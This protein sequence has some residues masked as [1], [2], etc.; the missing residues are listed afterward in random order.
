MFNLS[1]L[2]PLPYLKQSLIVFLMM[3]L[4]VPINYFFYPPQKAE[5]GGLGQI[6]TVVGDRSATGIKTMVES[7]LTTVNTFLTSIGITNLNLKE[8][9]WDGLFN[10]AA[11]VFLRAMVRSIIVWINSGFKGAPLFITDMKSFLLDVADETIGEMI[12]KNED[13]NFLCS[14]FQLDVKIALATTYSQGREGSYQPQCTLS[15]VTD[16]VEGFM[17]GAF[18]QGGWPG[19]LELTISE[20]SN[21]MQAYLGARME[22]YARII[23]AQGEEIAKR[24]V[25]KNMLNI[26][27]CDVAEKQAGTEENCLIGT[28]GSTI[29]EILN[30]ALGAEQEVLIEADEINEVFNALIS[31]IMKQ[32]FTG[33][34]GLL[35]LG[36]NSSYTNY[37]WDGSNGTSSILDAHEQDDI[38]TSIDTT[39]VGAASPIG[40][41]IADTERFIE[42]KYEI[43]G[44]INAAESNYN[45]SKSSLS[46]Q[47][48]NIGF[49]FP[50]SLTMDRQE[51]LNDIAIAETALEILLTMEEL[52]NNSTNAADQQVVL[53][54]YQRLKA[55]GRVVDQV[56][57]TDAELYLEYT[58]AL[59]IEELEDDIADA[60]RQ[61]EQQNDD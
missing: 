20:E 52:F 6:V 34:Y 14:P 17:S 22:G 44:R 40:Q 48:C 51:A 7:T 31:Q 21:P 46:D 37:D 29:A 43:V 50:S 47:G 3:I 18:D 28:P 45:N 1:K 33:A 35:G 23:N 38:N 42:L 36:G 10:M 4:L 39:Y 53:E 13:L 12:Y 19:F 41:S 26:T 32:V 49:N 15:Q 55:E 27:T 25:N 60:E 54:E 30:D 16:N 8:T 59:D 58:L 11:K 5:A 57:V 2:N 56:D 61:C 24:E 9:F